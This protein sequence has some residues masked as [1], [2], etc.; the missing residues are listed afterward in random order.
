[1]RRSHL[2]QGA[3]LRPRLSTKARSAIFCCKP[4]SGRMRRQAIGGG[5]TIGIATY[6]DQGQEQRQF[7]RGELKQAHQSRRKRGLTRWSKGRCLLAICRKGDASQ[8][9]DPAA[10]DRYSNFRNQFRKTTPPL[11]SETEE[12]VS[13]AASPAIARHN[14]ARFDSPKRISGLAVVRAAR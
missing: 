6:S 12:C 5:V 4:A 7:G 8:L 3:A 2:G 9:A 11:S 13:L 10:A 1:M 14:F